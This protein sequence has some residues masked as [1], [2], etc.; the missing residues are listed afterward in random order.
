MHIEKEEAK[1]SVFANDMTVYENNTPQK[2]I[3]GNLST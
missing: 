3:P 2:P 1:V